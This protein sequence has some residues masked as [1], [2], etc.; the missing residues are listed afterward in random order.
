MQQNLMKKT[1][2]YSIIFS[3][4][5]LG[6]TF[7]AVSTEA[8][9]IESKGKEEVQHIDEDIN[10]I[11][12]EIITDSEETKMADG[13]LTFELGGADT[14][15]L[16]IPLPQGVGAE[17]IAIENHYMDGEMWIALAEVPEGFYENSV[18]SGN[19]EKIIY[20]T[21]ENFNKGVILKFGLRDIY[22]CRSILESGSLYIELVAPREMYDKIIVVDPAFGG[23]SVGFE[24]N[25]LREKDI[26]L[27]V[28][29]KLKEKLDT[30]D[31]KVYYTRM[32]D[33]NP[34][35]EQ[36]VRV[37]NNTKADMLIRIEANAEGDSGIYG[38]TAI[39]NANFFIPGFGSIELANLLEKEVVSYI[40]GKAIGLQ[41]AD[42]T[43]YVVMQ[44]TVPAAT[45][46][47]GYMTN[48]QEAILLKKEDYLDKI[49]TGIYNAIMQVYEE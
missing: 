35:D 24:E 26:T 42:G 41:A 27:K 32:E 31:I 34:T 9:A 3:I 20:G 48:A 44:A 1:A 10:Y 18:I 17:G 38:T 19:R 8:I 36:R 28:A 2:I 23:K 12:S 22:E 49:A 5:A 4:A 16:C 33:T 6:V 39:Y 46:K 29:E 7:F 37:A 47:V 14:N 40:K 13:A 25:G 11:T 15:Y 45:I 30:T 43:D 21:F